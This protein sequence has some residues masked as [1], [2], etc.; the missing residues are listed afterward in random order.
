[1]YTVFVVELFRLVENLDRNPSPNSFMD[2]GAGRTGRGADH[3]P[4]CRRLSDDNLTQSE[5]SPCVMETCNYVV[6]NGYGHVV[7]INRL[8]G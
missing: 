6:T 8:A 4:E 5:M 1:M 7:R 3:G 2:R